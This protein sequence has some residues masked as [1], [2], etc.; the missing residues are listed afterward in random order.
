M[1][2]GKL[3]A[4]VSLIGKTHHGRIGLQTNK[5]TN[6]KISTDRQINYNTY[7]VSQINFSWFSCGS[8]ILIELEFEGVGSS[9]GNLHNDIFTTESRKVTLEELHF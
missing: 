6:Q 1:L 4:F 3:R 7:R 5:Q 2:R 8:S 9:S